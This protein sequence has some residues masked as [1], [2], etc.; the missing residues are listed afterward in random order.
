MFRSNVFFYVASIWCC[1]KSTTVC[2]KRFECF[3]SAVSLEFCWWGGSSKP[4][5]LRWF[6]LLF[7][8]PSGRSYTQTQVLVVTMIPPRIASDVRGAL[9]WR[10]RASSEGVCA[11]SIHT[12]VR[13]HESDIKTPNYR[14]AGLGLNPRRPRLEPW[15][16]RV[17]KFRPLIHQQFLLFLMLLLLLLLFG[18]CK[19][20]TSRRGFC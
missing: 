12:M 18:S 5:M 14:W 11:S 3:S 19:R 6:V 20:T 2:A 10:I 9:W 1:C 13:Q 8:N 7:T 4:Q 17:Q 15:R 16:H